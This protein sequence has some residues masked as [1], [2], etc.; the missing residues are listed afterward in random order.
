MEA[1]D[2]ILAGVDKLY[3]DY[4]QAW[5]EVHTILEVNNLFAKWIRNSSLHED[6]RR[7]QYT[8]LLIALEYVYLHYSA[9]E[10]DHLDIVPFWESDIPTEYP[11][12]ILART[13][14][15]LVI[16]RAQGLAMRAQKTSLGPL[17]DEVELPAHI[18]LGLA[19]LRHLYSRAWAES[20][21]WDEVNARIARQMLESSQRIDRWNTLTDCLVALEY[22]FWQYSSEGID[23]LG[24]IHLGSSCFNNERPSSVLARTRDALV[25]ARAEGLAIPGTRVFR[26]VPGASGNPDELPDDILYGIGLL[27]LSYDVALYNSKDWEHVYSKLAQSM[28][29]TSL[30]PHQTAYVVLMN[31]LEYLFRHYNSEEEIRRLPRFNTGRY[32]PLPWPEDLLVK[33]RDVLVAARARGLAERNRRIADGTLAAPRELPEVPAHVA[34]GFGQL[35]EAY[36]KGWQLYAS[37]EEVL[38]WLHDRIRSASRGDDRANPLTNALVALEYLFLTYDEDELA[39]LEAVRPDPAWPQGLLAR[40]RDMLAA[41]RARGIEECDGRLPLV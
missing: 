35:R 28:Y 36:A 33:S 29:D 7:N 20:T 37:W 21:S 23:I 41:G 11:S 1:P 8:Q 16:G 10:I 24:R 4:I 6:D 38:V 2:N 32:W 19:A 26:S 15:A 31:A 9:D 27:E 5:D 3:L 18:R 17:Q 12:Y 22:L 13:R 40:T 34:E 25:T 39:R 14:D 30:L